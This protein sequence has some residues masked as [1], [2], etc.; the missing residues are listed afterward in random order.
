MFE[1]DRL[2]MYFINEE[3]NLIV[4]KIKTGLRSGV[5]IKVPISGDYSIAGY[6]A[7]NKR[8]V[9]IKD[10]YNVEEL[11]SF[12]PPVFFFRDVDKS[13]GYKTKQ[14]LAAPVLSSAESKEV[15]G[16]LQFINTLSGKP[17]SKSAEVQILELCKALSDSLQRPEKTIRILPPRAKTRYDY[18]VIDA[19][20]NSAELDLAMRQ[21]RSK[22]GDVERVLTESF[23]VSN[24]A[25]GMALSKWYGVPYEP[26]VPGRSRPTLLLKG[27]KRRFIKSQGWLPIEEGPEGVT[28]LTTDPERAIGSN[29]AR[30]VF[31]K[32]SAV[33][34]VCTNKDFAATVEQFYG[35]EESASS[36]DTIIK[37]LGD[38]LAESEGEEGEKVELDSVV[39]QLVNKI[40]L[41]AHKAGASD[42]HIEPRQ[43]R[44]KSRVRFRV[45]GSLTDYTEVPASYHERLVARLKVMA[46]LDMSNR[47]EPQDGKISFG[48]FNAALDIEL[49]IA[50]VPTISGKEDV[51]LRILSA[52]RPVPL[53]ELGMDDGIRDT[54]RSLVSRSHGLFLVCGPTG[55]GKTT[56]LHSV[57]DLIN[58][59]DTK[60]W[61]AEDPVEITN[62]SL[63]QVQVN[64]RTDFT[65]ARAMRAF[66]RADP[67]VIMLGEMRD[68]E[69]AAIG[70]EASLTGHRVFTTI[71]TN[72]AAE[73]IVR[74]LDMG[75]D[76]FNFGDA[77]LGVMAQRLAK[78]LCE[79]CKKPHVA[80]EEEIDAFLTEYL[81]DLSLIRHSEEDARVMRQA[82]LEDWRNHYA[83]E[84][85]R[86]VLYDKVGCASCRSTG[87]SGRIALHELMVATPAIKRNIAERTHVT[88]I[89]KTALKE[90]MRSLRQDGIRKVLQGLTDIHAV[91][92]VCA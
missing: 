45:D 63:R 57:I 39:V 5:E 29:I 15:L 11:S 31:P 4:S 56:T 92:A 47:R 78:R 16:V 53:H 72:S 69:T 14:V 42:I 88:E 43:G 61:T 25:L 18:L 58:K 27:L 90:G 59:P 66:L 64:P 17:F 35:G 62:E 38:D 30:Q 67:D 13:T 10:V 44:S 49:R 82:V 65:F 33:Y 19:V 8:M 20:I 1:A 2:T 9:N 60:I 80:A 84:K 12:D 21:A 71:H 74:L 40:I 34:R 3:K 55:S 83:Y 28:I 70:V 87:Y 46:E 86:F 48:G 26:F 41:E 73:S 91:R 24:E 6:V 75:M 23:Q 79:K 37:Q 51:V 76:P 22:G 52:G 7:F 85:V 89:S 81:R 32:K 36:I 68:R 77:L 54:V 50:T